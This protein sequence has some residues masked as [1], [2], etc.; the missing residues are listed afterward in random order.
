MFD[1]DLLDGIVVVCML[2][3]V[4]GFVWRQ[5]QVWQTLGACPIDQGA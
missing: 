4:F 5:A 1:A 3:H 2:E